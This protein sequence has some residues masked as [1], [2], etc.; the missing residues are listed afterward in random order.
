M[1][2]DVE[3]RPPNEPGRFTSSGCR[4]K[5]RSLDKVTDAVVVSS[6]PPVKFNHERVGL[7]VGDLGVGGF[8][9]D[10]KGVIN[11]EEINVCLP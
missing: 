2:C 9:S 8:G 11:L 1:G 7:G 5:T 4:C 6:F 10:G 3:R